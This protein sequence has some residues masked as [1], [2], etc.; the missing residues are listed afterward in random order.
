M[1]ETG[2]AKTRGRFF[3]KGP[4]HVLHVQE[5]KAMAVVQPNP[6]VAG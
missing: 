5:R 2:I 4:R 3:V 1:C 6:H